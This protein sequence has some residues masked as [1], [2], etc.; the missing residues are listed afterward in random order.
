MGK[1]SLR[2]LLL[3]I[4]AL[5]FLSQTALANGNVT[6]VAT[7]KLPLYRTL[8]ELKDYRQHLTIYNPNY[9]RFGELYFGN[10]V[11]ILEENQYAVKV[12]TTDGQEGWVQ[13]DYLSQNP[14]SHDWL[15]KDERALKSEP[16]MKASTIATVPSKSKV[17][18]LDFKFIST[19][20]Y[21]DW[22]KV[23]T[24]NGSVGWIWGAHYIDSD[25]VNR[26]S[27]IIRYEFEKSGTISNWLS[28]FAP[29][30]TYAN[31]TAGELNA[32]I[33][34]KANGSNTLMTG[35]GSSFIE[36]QNTTGLNAI[37][38]MAH[39]GH[40]TG[41]GKSAISQNKYNYYGIGAIDSKPAQ[42]A[43]TFNNP[44][45]GIVAGAIWI[46]ENYIIRGWD[47]DRNYPFYQSTL[48]N[49]KNDNGGWHQY[50]TDEAWAVK[51]GNFIDQY[52]AFTYPNG[53]AMKKGWYQEGTEYYYFDSNGKMV[54]G[55]LPWNGIWY[56]LKQ[57]GYMAKGWAWDKG[58]WYYFNADGAMQTGWVLDKGIWYYIKPDGKM[59]SNQWYYQ[60]GNWYY[61]KKD[62]A[63]ST[64]WVH[65][66]VA[67]YYHNQNGYMQTGWI[68]D[69][70]LWYYLK[71]DGK[72]MSN[73]WYYQNGNW[74]YMKKDGVM[75]TGWLNDGANWYYH[76]Q[77]GYMQTGWTKVNGTWYFM[78]GSGVMKTGW[79]YD[80]AWY[81]LSGGGAMQTGWKFIGGN[82]YYFYSG[83]S[84]AANTTIDG[85]R[86]GSSG[87]WIQ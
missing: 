87:A 68:K 50:A 33:A 53:F 8:D 83:G 12:R 59:M 73:Q 42:G 70:G 60:N 27:N 69:N 6:Y 72:M 85:F 34:S 77:D 18:V 29:L 84:M 10:Q 57:N 47:T 37:Y 52:Y 46:G 49:M 9:T 64:G 5:L 15:V 63:M 13:K 45:D 20:Q 79:L 2:V 32:F 14:T 80:G 16:Y 55:W 67:W 19:E 24:A 28:V 44:H 40:E 58:S 81:Y 66:G 56:Y 7:G 31:I 3:S 82:W 36:A 41:W 39:A 51:I 75:S 4:L 17:K 62:G 78:N 76:N 71:P 26:G 23:Q 1:A 25:W 65:D 21:K 74:Y 22:Y 54:T 30:N 86:L 11:T 48:D 35:M 43:Y 38:L 61:M